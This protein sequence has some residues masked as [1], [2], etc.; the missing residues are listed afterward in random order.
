[1]TTEEELLAAAE[2]L[3]RLRDKRAAEIGQAGEAKAVYDKEHGEAVGA[4]AEMA[5]ALEDFR[6]KASSYTKPDDVIP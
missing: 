2:T 5:A 6:T 1:M 4:D 3:V